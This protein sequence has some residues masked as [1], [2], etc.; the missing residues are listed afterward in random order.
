MPRTWEERFGTEIVCVGHDTL[1]F[2]VTRSPVTREQY[3]YCPDIVDQGV[4]DVLPLAATLLGA[5]KWFFWW[6]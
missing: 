2:E 5:S 4:G 1:E 6:D 3:L